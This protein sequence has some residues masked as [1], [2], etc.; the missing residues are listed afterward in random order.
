M[1]DFGFYNMDNMKGMAQFPDKYFDLAIVD[2]PYGIGESSNNNASRG[3]GRG[4]LQNNA[5]GY[6]SEW[7]LKG[8]DNKPPE[9]E[10]FV[11]LFRISKNQIIWGANHFLDSFPHCVNASCWIVWDKKNGANDFAD[12]ELAWTSFESAVRKFD[13][14]WHGLLQQDMKK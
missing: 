14:R 2:P 4:G 10:Y 7:T 8:W 5:L 1:L 13:W 9:K 3:R 6:A 12:C 11:E